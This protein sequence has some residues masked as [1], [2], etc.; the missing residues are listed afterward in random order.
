MLTKAL[1]TGLPF[2]CSPTYP[3]TYHPSFLH[4]SRTMPP[5]ASASAPSPRLAPPSSPSPAAAPPSPGAASL[6]ES[7]SH[8]KHRRVPSFDH[9]ISK[10]K[11]MVSRLPSIHSSSSPFSA[12]AAATA[13]LN[14]AGI[15][16]AS[17]GKIDKSTYVNWAGLSTLI[18]HKDGEGVMRDEAISP[19][20]STFLVAHSTKSSKAERASR[21]QQQQ[22][23]QMIHLEKMTDPNDPSEIIFKITST[24][25]SRPSAPKGPAPSANLPVPPAA[26]SPAEEKGSKTSRIVTALL[27]ASL[28]LKPAMQSCLK[29]SYRFSLPFT[30]SVYPTESLV[31]PATA[32]AECGEDSL[33][34]QTSIAQYATEV[35]QEEAA[36]RASD[37]DVQSDFE[38]E[39]FKWVDAEL[40]MAEEAVKAMAD[41]ELYPAAP[42]GEEEE[43]YAP[44]DDGGYYAD[45][46]NSPCLGFEQYKKG[47]SIHS[48]QL[49]KAHEAKR[50][51]ARAALLSLRSASHHQ[52]QKTEKETAPV[53]DPSL[54]AVPKTPRFCLDTEIVPRIGS[55]SVEQQEQQ[56][57][58]QEQRRAPRRKDSII[59]LPGQEAPLVNPSDAANA[60]LTTE[61]HHSHRSRTR[62]KTINVGPPTPFNWTLH[63]EQQKQNVHDLRARAE[64]FCD[65]TLEQQG[66]ARLVQRIRSRS[67]PEL[68][69]ILDAVG[70][71]SLHSEPAASAELK[72]DLATRRM[73]RLQQRRPP[74][75]KL[76]DLPDAKEWATVEIEVNG[77][78]LSDRD[79]SMPAVYDPRVEDSSQETQEQAKE[80]EAIHER[81][82]HLQI[83]ERHARLIRKK[84]AP[85]TTTPPLRR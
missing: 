38:R 61:D 3:P 17:T 72:P 28:L 10:L 57:T 26:A 56:A 82:E 23:K 55:P 42:E 47:G 62:A 7:P 67:A 11:P 51:A 1:L 24:S 49:R 53:E 76:K 68:E 48:H 6:A 44:D 75:L 4:L 60:S 78:R 43:M 71:M 19:L 33:A 8:P 52:Q 5:T 70:A 13:G 64:V 25:T 83:P 41:A 29:N 79:M 22:P 50:K 80:P 45:L 18:H 27:P 35:E 20:R 34:S 21:Q 2:P 66:D 65:P 14:A 81:P 59:V 73:S 30:P 31:F 32:D 15:A 69:G 36:R 16:G 74:S 58:A 77:T 12:H 39:L 63:Q 37:P 9:V 84:P 46:D 54:L 40:Q 85:E